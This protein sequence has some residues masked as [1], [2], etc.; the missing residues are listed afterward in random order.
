MVSCLTENCQPPPYDDSDAF[1]LNENTPPPSYDKSS[2]FKKPL[3][4]HNGKTYYG[5]KK[6]VLGSM[7]QFKNIIDILLMTSDTLFELKGSLPE[8]LINMYI[9]SCY[10]DVIDFARILSNDFIEFIK[11]VDLYPTNILSVEKLEM[12]IVKYCKINIFDHSQLEELC[13]RHGLKHLHLF[14]HKNNQ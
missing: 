4:K 14:L 5:H 12:E 10:S 2:Q 13:D 11:F 9:E 1:N 8:Y 6:I 3:F 7:V